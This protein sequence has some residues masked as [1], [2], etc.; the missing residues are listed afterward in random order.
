MV[1]VELT[2]NFGAVD[3]LGPRCWRWKSPVCCVMFSCIG[4]FYLSDAIA[5]SPL[6]VTPKMSPDLAKCLMDGKNAPG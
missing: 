2:V 3:I 5:P 6:T 1:S 4:S